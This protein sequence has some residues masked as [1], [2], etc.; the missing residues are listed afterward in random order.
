MEVKEFIDALQNKLA[1]PL[2]V[3]DVNY[4]QKFYYA[5]YSVKETLAI[6]TSPLRDAF[7][8]EPKGG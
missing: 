7:R 1:K 6:I 3:S 8:Y 5:G 2:T 4:L